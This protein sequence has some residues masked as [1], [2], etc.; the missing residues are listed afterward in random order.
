MAQV[1]VDVSKNMATI[2]MKKG[3]LDQKKVAAAFKDSRYTV[4]SFKSLTPSVILYTLNVTGM[5]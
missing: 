5:T 2:T 3:E 4:S 1:E